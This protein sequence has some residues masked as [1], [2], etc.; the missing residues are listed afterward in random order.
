MSHDHSHHDSA[1]MAEMLDLDAEVLGSYLADATNWV[2]DLSVG[3][4]VRR[5][6]DLGCGTGNGALALAGRFPDAEVTAVDKSPEFLGRVKARAGDLGRADRVRVIEADL[7][8]PWPDLGSVDLTW[9]SLALHHLADPDRGLAKLLA[10]TSPGGLV[11]VAEMSSQV[12]F[13]PDDLGFGEPGLEARVHAVLAQRRAAELPHLGAD[14][15]ERLAGAGF[16]VIADRTF[17]IDLISPLPES[18][19]RLAQIF[20]GRLRSE[21][22]DALSA[23]DLAALDVVLADDGPGSVRRRQD[24]EIRGTRTLWVGRRP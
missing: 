22:D 4:P 24:L 13:L 8:G 15:G 2:H 7:D 11:A 21:F 19:G 17:E 23:E 18:A 12:R 1:A 6:L 16:A 3:V 5:I 20:L 14:W 10:A 9:T